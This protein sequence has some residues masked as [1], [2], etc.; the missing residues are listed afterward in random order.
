MKAHADPSCRDL[1]CG[2]LLLSECRLSVADNLVRGVLQ[3]DAGPPTPRGAFR[4][5]QPPIVAGVDERHAAA[6]A[7]GCM[8][9]RMGKPY[10]AGLKSRSTVG[11]SAHCRSSET[12]T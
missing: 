1:R 4:P 6:V 5:Y 11:S 7:A 8:R 10:E 9:N 3:A 2:P 12:V